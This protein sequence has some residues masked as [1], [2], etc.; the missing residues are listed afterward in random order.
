MAQLFRSDKRHRREIPLRLQVLQSPLPDSLRVR[1]F[2]ELQYDP[3][4]KY[5]TWVR[6]AIQL[7]LGIR[8]KPNYSDAS[9]PLRDALRRARSVMDD[10][11]TGHDLAK[12]EV[13]A[14]ICNARSGSGSSYAIGLEGPPGC[15]K[16]TFVREALARALDLPLVSIPLG[17]ACDS[18]YLLG[19][20]FTYE[21][22]KEGRIAAGLIE[23]G[24]CNPII[25]F[26]ELD[27]VARR[28]ERGGEIEAALIHLIDKSACVQRDRYFHDI[29]IDFKDVTFVFG[30]N[31]PNDVNPVLLD[32]IKRVRMD[33]PS[34]DE[35]FAIV[36]QHMLP[37]L[38]KRFETDVKLSDE[39][40]GSIVEHGRS[41][42]G[43]RD[44]EKDLTHVLSSAQLCA[45]LDG[46]SE[47]IGLPKDVRVFDE[48]GFVAR[49]F[50]ENCLRAVRAEDDAGPPMAMY[51]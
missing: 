37:R 48:R 44:V 19:S 30:Y 35:R 29:D 17:G 22:S 26:D 33:A 50:A 5:A 46:R 51:T 15:G 28:S 27:K 11:I 14:A 38:S 36:R 2:D 47:A 42:S 25:F 39:A 21:G 24:C 3:N 41:L 34:R 20:T 4:P 23:A 32:R 49:S 43:M 7:P 8:K 18:C 13:L 10:A 31:N 45:G 1:I 40:I 16:T 6:K 9:T 12:R